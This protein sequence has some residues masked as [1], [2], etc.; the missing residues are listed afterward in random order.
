MDSNSFVELPGFSEIL[1]QHHMS[2]PVEYVSENYSQRNVNFD[3]LLKV[4]KEP[5][6]L[7]LESECQLASRLSMA[8]TDIKSA[9]ELL[10]DAESTLRILKLGSGEEQSNYLTIWSKIAFVCSQELKHGAY[11]WKEAVKKNAHDQLLSIPKGVQYVHALGEIYRV[12]EI[13][14]VS[15]KLHKPWMLSG[16][17]DCTSLFALL[18]ECNSLWLASGLEEALSSISNH[19]NLD[20]DGI[21]RELVQSIKYIDEL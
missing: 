2:V 1:H 20:A 3:E 13:V 7:P 15:A 6:F 17:I 4:L 16:S 10:K 12:A 8:K 9:M 14:R 5:K 11:I 21:S 18:D 19:N